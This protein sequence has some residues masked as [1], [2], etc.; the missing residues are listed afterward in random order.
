VLFIRELLAR[1][2]NFGK[3]MNNIRRPR[4][5]TCCKILLVDTRA[6]RLD[7]ASLQFTLKRKLNM[8]NLLV[9]S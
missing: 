4:G 7:Y 9:N 8:S 5:P 1:W 6:R 3:G 2:L